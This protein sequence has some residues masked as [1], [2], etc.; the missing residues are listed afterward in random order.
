MLIIEKDYK[1]KVCLCEQCQILNAGPVK[2]CPI[3]GGKTTE[4]DVIEEIIE[5]AQRTN[6]RIEFTDDEFLEKL[7]HIGGL[8]RYN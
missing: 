6:A 2:N 3:C 1:L 4:S 5:F 8:L 7:G